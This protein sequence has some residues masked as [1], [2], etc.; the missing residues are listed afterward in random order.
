[1]ARSGLL[2]AA[3][4][5]L[6][7]F[8]DPLAPCRTAAVRDVST[9]LEER[10]SPAEAL[11]PSGGNGIAKGE[12]FGSLNRPSESSVSV[13]ETAGTEGPPPAAAPSQAGRSAPET[14]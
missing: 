3:A 5:L 11:L 8:P 2:R 13:T 6:L 4:P 1:M 14:L 10:L 9:G 12:L 7:P